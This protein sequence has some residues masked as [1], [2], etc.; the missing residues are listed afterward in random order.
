MVTK[1][2]A[3][4]KIPLK[5][6]IHIQLPK[7]FVLIET[8]QRVHKTKESVTRPHMNFMFILTINLCLCGHWFIR[9]QNVN[10]GT[11]KH[12]FFQKKIYL[13][14]FG[15]LLPSVGCSHFHLKSIVCS[16][17]IR[18]PFFVPANLHD[19]KQSIVELNIDSRQTH[20]WQH[21]HRCYRKALGTVFS[22]FCP[23]AFTVRT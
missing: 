13:E 20:K 4:S 18:F 9:F 8:K 19:I 6:H 7:H 11:W 15:S 1:K 21:F 16:T 23:S 10:K 22:S 2:R 3:A 5:F 17:N 14:E 12:F